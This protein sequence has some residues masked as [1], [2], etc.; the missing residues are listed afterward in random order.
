LVALGLLVLTAV[1]GYR[2]YRFSVYY[3]GE[4]FLQFLVLKEAEEKKGSSDKAS[5]ET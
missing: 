4:L 1:Y 3:G 5:Q 2:A